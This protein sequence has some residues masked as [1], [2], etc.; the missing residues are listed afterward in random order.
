MGMGASFRAA[1]LV[2]FRT[3]SPGSDP[4]VTPTRTKREM[5][6]A[7]A[8]GHRPDG[9]VGAISEARIVVMTVDLENVMP[10]GA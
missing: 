5:E 2:G 1:F 9:L 10:R 8:A 3:I 6:E 7:T 4:H